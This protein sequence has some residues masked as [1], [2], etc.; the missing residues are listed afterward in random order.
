MQ[1]KVNKIS[2][3]TSSWSPDLV[4]KNIFADCLLKN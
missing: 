3:G 2:L 1:S 4:T